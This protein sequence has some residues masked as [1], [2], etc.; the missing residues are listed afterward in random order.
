MKH[1]EFNPLFYQTNTCTP[2]VSHAKGIYIWDDSGKKYIDGSSGAIIC[3][4]GHG[5]QS[6]IAAIKQQA[7]STFFT[8]RT[9][10]ENVPAVRLAQRLVE[11]M[12][13]GLDRVFYVS[14][15]SEAVESAVKLCRS[16]YCARKQEGKHIFISRSPSYH[17]STL[18][19]LALTSYAPLEIPYRPLLKSCPKIPAPYCYRCHY[20]KTYPSCN[21]ACA[22]ALEQEIIEQGADNVAGFIAEPI[23][24]A[25][26]GAL[27]PPD[28]Y[29]SVI[30]DICDRHDVL[31]IFD[32]VMTGFGRTGKL[33]AHEHW[34]VIPDIMALSKGMASGYYPLGAVVTSGKI[35]D[36]VLSAGGFP[37]GHTYAGNPMACAVGLAVLDEIINNRL[38]ANAETMGRHLK[39]GL[40]KL[41]EKYEII[42]EV[43]G[44]GLLTAIELVQDKSNRTPYGPELAAG[45]MLT[46]AAFSQGL[47]IY[48]RRSVN[49][50]KGDHVLIAP[51]II[52]SKTQ[53]N[54]LLTILDESLKNIEQL[55]KKENR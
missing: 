12:S 27:V 19:A 11:H 51:P 49:G 10:F 23:G 13:P 28:D 54:D 22:H 41:A 29:F 26:T 5:N 37:H 48:P 53:V 16:Y 45:S 17:G 34:R 15:G 38:S 14:G 32:E 43:R 55:L 44:A 40:R 8:Y 20:G 46:K 2:I 31:L 25:S 35:V 52:I 33:F 24:G 39:S 6:V 9:Q 4:I 3:N 21:L 30:R 47:I 18:G 1:S 7:E 36:S 42:G 50:L